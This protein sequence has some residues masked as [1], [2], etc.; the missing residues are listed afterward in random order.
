MK[1]IFSFLIAILLIAV[2]LC[3]CGDD[4]KNATIYYELPYFPSTLDPSVISDATQTMISSNLYEG[5]MRL[6]YD[7]NV[8]CGIAEKYEVNGNTFTFTLRDDTK[9]SNGDPLLAKDFVFGLKRSIDPKTN[10][11]LA[12]NLFCIKN[13]KEIFEGKLS[14]D[15][16]GVKAID[17]KTLI[18]E[19]VSDGLLKALTTPVAMPCNE[20][21][22]NKASGEYGMTATML[23]S[24]GSYRI[25]LWDF[26]NKKIR[27]SK[28]PYYNGNFSPENSNVIFTKSDELTP[29]ERLENGNVDMAEI[30]TASIGTAKDLQLN[31]KTIENTVWL[32]TINDNTFSK[33]LRTAF[34]SSFNRNKYSGALTL[35]YR[36]T[37]DVFP[38]ALKGEN[39]NL[40]K[41]TFDS[42]LPQSLFKNA[43]G[44][45]Q[46]PTINIV[47]YDDPVMKKSLVDI[48][49]NWQ[50]LFGVTINLT[51]S[52]NLSDLQSQLKEKTYDMCL[53]PI[54]SNDG[55]FVNYLNYFGVNDTNLQKAQDTILKDY[56]VIPVA[57]QDT[58]YAMTSNITK[59]NISLRSEIIDFSF[60]I[61]ND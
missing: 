1:K 39:A 12:K 5:L 52:T 56:S 17:D 44:K 53:F 60:V 47:Y 21:F 34:I 41:L 58:C 36:I 51:P 20:T 6:D 33:D 50:Q 49:G 40:S 54:T 13:A 19:T 25:R 7:L 48:A 45:D 16:L 32:M 10:S 18:F 9:W 55:S 35:G 38:A 22:F 37:E 23:L 15:N 31:C 57:V 27:I 28:N 43:I 14:V 11:P 59:T 4:Y 42:V 8:V 61:K 29:I 2:S 24:N 46:L 30:D 3:G 26:E